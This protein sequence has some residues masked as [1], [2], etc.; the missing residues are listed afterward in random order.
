MFE[1][2]PER[3]QVGQVEADDPTYCFDFEADGVTVRVTIG[4]ADFRQLIEGA[5]AKLA[6]TP[7]E[8]NGNGKPSPIQIAR[9]M[10][11][12]RTTLG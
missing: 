5:A 8:A 7:A 12:P 3:I 11:T 6:E 10:P 1:I 9:A 2:A 4:S